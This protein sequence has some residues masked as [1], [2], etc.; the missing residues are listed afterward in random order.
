MKKLVLGLFIMVIFIVGTSIPT[1]VSADTETIKMDPNVKYIMEKTGSSEYEA[2]MINEIMLQ[3]CGTQLVYKLWVAHHDG[4]KNVNASYNEQLKIMLKRNTHYLGKIGT[5]DGIM[6]KY[7]NYNLTEKAQILNIKPTDAEFMN[8]LS[9]SNDN[10]LKIYVS[11]RTEN[12]VKNI[13]SKGT[14]LKKVANKVKENPISLTN[15]ENLKSKAENMN[16]SIND[17]VEDVNTAMI[18]Y[19]I[20]KNNPEELEK[21]YHNN[22]S[23]A[24]LGAFVNNSILEVNK[25]MINEWKE[26]A[27]SGWK[28]LAKT[29]EIMQISGNGLAIL[30]AVIKVI[31][32]TLGFICGVVTISTVG[33]FSVTSS[34]VLVLD[35]ITTA[36]SIIAFILGQAGK[37]IR[38]T[39][40]DMMKLYGGTYDYFFWK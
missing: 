14:E 12:D 20:L 39:A 23:K 19:N 22:S 38:K 2:G 16:N 30:S 13:A 26:T 25:S 35:K 21:A 36:I 15:A 6:Q 40:E 17:Y 34:V 9:E 28:E 33:V 7:A 5:Y 3:T 4:F 27:K 1:T 11:I 18:E 24:V 31:V 32:W 8:N 37:F 10:Q 29:G